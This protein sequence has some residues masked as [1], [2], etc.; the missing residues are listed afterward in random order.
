MTFSRSLPINELE[1]AEAINAL[2]GLVPDEQLR[3]RAARLDG[4]R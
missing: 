2:R 3:A 4:E 1:Q